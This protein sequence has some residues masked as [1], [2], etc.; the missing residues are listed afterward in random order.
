MVRTESRP[1]LV[2]GVP[3]DGAISFAG[4]FPTVDGGIAPTF[5]KWTAPFENA[6]FSSASLE[7]VRQ[8]RV[9]YH[10]DARHFQGIILD[11]ANGTRRALG[12]C[13]LGLDPVVQSN[14]PFSICYAHKPF[15]SPNTR[16]TLYRVDVVFRGDE[17]CQREDTELLK[18]TCCAME[19][20]VQV[21]FAE[22]QTRLNVLRNKC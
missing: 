3:T 8:A 7:N 17:G 18:W 6:C 14:K 1:T 5:A 19:G 2:Y 22:S 20:T 16:A 11:Y 13:R 15:V 9:Y 21:W 10:K 4:A 12:Q